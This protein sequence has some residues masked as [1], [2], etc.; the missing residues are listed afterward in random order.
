MGAAIVINAV[1]CNNS[2]Y[3]ETT[4]H[5]I[6]V[7]NWILSKFTLQPKASKTTLK[8]PNHL[9]LNQPKMSSDTEEIIQ[10]HFNTLH[11]SSQVA[12]LKPTPN[13]KDN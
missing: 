10:K 8:S 4:A 7:F 5:Y 13:C 9:Q 11:E 6:T 1:H 12:N 3:V 2:I